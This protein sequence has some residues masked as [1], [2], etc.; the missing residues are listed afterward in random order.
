MSH[1]SL[2]MLMLPVEVAVVGFTIILDAL[3]VVVGAVVFS[4][5]LD[6]TPLSL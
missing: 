5:L 3:A 1:Y 4:N 6:F 2:A